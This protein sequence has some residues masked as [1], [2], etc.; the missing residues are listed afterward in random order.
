MT[1]EWQVEKIQQ[2]FQWLTTNHQLS[3]FFQC[4]VMFEKQ[5]LNQRQKQLGVTLMFLFSSKKEKATS[6]G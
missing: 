1:D 2:T 6:Q 3:V 4:V 5:I